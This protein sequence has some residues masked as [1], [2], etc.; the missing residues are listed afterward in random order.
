ME[1]NGKRVL[2]DAIEFVSEGRP[3]YCSKVCEAIAGNHVYS[4]LIQL[5]ARE[6]QIASL[7][8]EDLLSKEIADKLC[9]SVHTISSYR[10]TIL[11]KLK[12]KTTGGLVR[13]LADNDFFD[14]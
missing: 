14:R 3:Y 6:R 2:T 5:S 11:K 8:S 7:I 1:G 4:P 10:K 12:V 9:L 13:K